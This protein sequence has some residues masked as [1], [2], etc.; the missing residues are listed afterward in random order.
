MLDDYLDDDRV[1]IVEYDPHWPAAF[2]QEKS[3]V[4]AVLSVLPT[5]IQHIGST[6][7]PGLRAKPV[8]DLLVAVSSFA[9]VAEYEQRLEPLGYV[10]IVQ[11][12]EPVRIFFRKG[13]PRTH[14]L[15][16]VEDGSCEHHRL[17]RFRD[18]L[19]RHPETALAYEDLKR[20]LAVR[21]PWIARGIPR[22]RPIS[23][24]VS[25]PLPMQN[26]LKRRRAVS[27]RERPAE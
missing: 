9:P 12:N 3:A 15:H 25:S 26:W 6:A 4:C 1:V 23:S 2:E 5:D 22:A 16:I 13:S 14:H 27:R 7:I 8:I 10:H 11:P 24:R 21:L 20:D 19:L 18:Y 17:I